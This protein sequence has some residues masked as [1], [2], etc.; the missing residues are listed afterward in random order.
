MIYRRQPPAPEGKQPRK[1]VSA[2]VY[3]AFEDEAAR[4]R[5]WADLMADNG[6]LTID[7]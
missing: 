1:A 2:T 4:E 6:L 7:H 5:V 3:L